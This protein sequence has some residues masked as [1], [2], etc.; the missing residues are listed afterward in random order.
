MK[1]TFGMPGMDLRSGWAKLK[2]NSRLKCFLIRKVE[3][4]FTPG[5]PN[6]SLSG[7]FQSNHKISMN[8]TF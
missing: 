4:I 8:I 5:T 1:I 6:Q 7:R 2:V 3:S